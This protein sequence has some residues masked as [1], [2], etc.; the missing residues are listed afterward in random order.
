MSIAETILRKK[1]ATAKAAEFVAFVG[2]RESEAA[3]HRMVLDQALPHVH[4][5]VGT[6]DDAIAY[7]KAVDHAPA[8]LLVDLSDS[9]MP[10][11]DLARLSD[12]CEPSVGVFALGERNDVGL[13]R[14]LLQ[15]GVVDYL[16]K[17]LTVELLQRTIFAAEGQQQARSGKIVAML[18]TRGG[19]GTTTIALNLGRYLADDTHRRVVYVDANLHGGAANSMLGLEANNG[20]VDALQN[21][22][23]I[24]AP[25][26]QRALLAKSARFYVLSSALELQSDYQPKPGDFIELL[27]TLTAQFHYVIVDVGRPGSLLSTETLKQAR[28]TFVVADHSVHSVKEAI[29]IIRHVEDSSGAA[30]ASLILNRPMAS[31]TGRVQSPD[32]AKAVGR[33]VLEDIPHDSKMLATAENL[34]E[35]T[36]VREGGPFAQSIVHLAANLTG[37]QKISGS[38]WLT[39]MMPKRGK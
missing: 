20:L 27:A 39:K 13:F 7:L 12:V 32:F 9:A 28:R 1:N 21:V 22:R 26:L 3:L 31:S 18:G 34:G 16:V 14:S 19:I 11:S 33:T 35:S 2:D 4:I 10:L 23:R 15:L 24:D 8:K 38:S 17:P 30:S 36:E 6:L 37:Q 29:R 5:E 25:F